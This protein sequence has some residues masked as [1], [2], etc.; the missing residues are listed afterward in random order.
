MVGQIGKEKNSVPCS[1]FG[2]IDSRL[3]NGNV[4]TNCNLIVYPW[5]KARAPC[6]KDSRWRAFTPLADGAGGREGKGR[7]HR[8]AAMAA[9]ERSERAAFAVRPFVR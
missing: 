3:I 1:K 7:G 6:M 8:H 2:R 9:T 4:D 5:Q